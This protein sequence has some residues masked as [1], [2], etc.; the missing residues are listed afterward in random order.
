MA[1]FRAKFGR[2]YDANAE[3]DEGAKD[4]NAA[5]GAKDAEK[6]R[7]Q[8]EEEEDNLLDLISS[9]GQESPEQ[10]GADKPKFG[11]KK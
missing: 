6:Q 2:L 11:K 5:D 3:E 10:V 8:D 1:A 7:K 9:F 4:A